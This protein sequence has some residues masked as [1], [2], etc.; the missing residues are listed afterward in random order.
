MAYGLFILHLARK[1]SGHGWLLYD[2]AFR[3]QIA[4]GSLLAWTDL[5]ASMMASTV[6]SAPD[7]AGGHFCPLCQAVKRLS[8]SLHKSPGTAGRHCISTPVR[9]L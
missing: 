2:T 7:L 8:L 3:Q 6:L 4:A 5:N 1:H 9:N